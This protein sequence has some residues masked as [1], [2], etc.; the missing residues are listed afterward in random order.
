MKLAYLDCSSGISGDMFLA[1]LLDAG[2][3]LDRLRGELAKIDLGPYE[4][5]ESRVMRK[6]LAGNLVEIVVPD[7]QPHRH[8]S[9]IEKLIGSAALDEAVKQKALQVFRRLGEA[10]AR[11]HN[12]PIEKIH[13]HEVGAV[14]AIL[15]IVGGCLGLAMLGS[16]ELVCSPLNVGSGSVEAAHGSLPVPAPATAEL[17]KGI[18]VYSSGVE[19]ELVTPTGAALVSTLATGFGPVP[20]MIIERIG[21]G[22]GA[23]DFPTHPNIARLMLGEKAE[24]AGTASSGAGDETVLV[25]EANIDDMNPQLYGYFAEKALAAGAL[26]VTCSPLQMKKNRPGLLV[27]V[28]CRRELES[29]LARLLFEQTTTIGVRITEA[30]RKVLGREVVTVETAYGA[31]KMKVARLDGE[32][33]NAAPEFDDCKR[34]A[35]EK[36]VPLKEVMLAAQVAYRKLGH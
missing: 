33:V 23:K 15:D 13:F 3:E 8:L 7:K 35:D 24:G 16:P 36:S 20:A 2:V 28:I 29:A 19:S 14:D 25:I 12:Q 30:R 17:L 4:F 18:P 22:A 10:E 31:V 21:Y 9:H 27:N 32:I 11:L 6:G 34:L 5:T 1:A 26:D